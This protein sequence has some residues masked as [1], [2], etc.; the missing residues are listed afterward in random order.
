M[1]GWV[2]FGGCGRYHIACMVIVMVMVMCIVQL[3]T[4][5][6][7]NKTVGIHSTDVGLVVVSMPSIYAIQML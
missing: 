2:G 1:R 5:W 4:P 6:L 7:Y 3:S